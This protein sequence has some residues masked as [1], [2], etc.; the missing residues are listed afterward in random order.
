[1][2][3]VPRASSQPNSTPRTNA[4]TVVLPASLRPNTT[5]RCGENGPTTLSLNAPKLVILMLLR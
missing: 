2:L 5:L 1:M 3:R 4:E